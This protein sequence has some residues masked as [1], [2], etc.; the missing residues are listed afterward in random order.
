M[1]KRIISY[2]I[3]VT[4]LISLSHASVYALQT[5]LPFKVENVKTHVTF[6]SGYDLCM[7]LGDILL[8]VKI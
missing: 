4:M 2:L 7:P 5:N 8:D 6:W 3:I 1:K